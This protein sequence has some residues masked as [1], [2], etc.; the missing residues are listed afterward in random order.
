MG[1]PYRTEAGYTFP[2]FEVTI[3]PEQQRRL[4]GHCDIP[5]S[6]YS[7]SADPT[8]IARDTITLNTQTILANHPERAPVCTV[9]RI[10]QHRPDRTGETLEMSGRITAIEDHPKGRTITS[11]SEYRDT[12]G[13]VAFVV[14]PDVLMTGP[15]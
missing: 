3:T 9:H 5:E 8:F 13:E 4:H 7:D 2:T 14:T 6:V 15:T 12:N 1:V 11:L 10:E